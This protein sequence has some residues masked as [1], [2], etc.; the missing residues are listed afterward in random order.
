MFSKATEY[1]LRAAIYIAQKS[2]EDKKLSLDEIARGINSPKSF[3]AKTLQ[4]LS[5][6]NKIV[7][8]KTGPNGGF[9][10]TERARRLPAR[11]ILE[12]M[13]EDDLLEKCVLGLQQCSDKKPCPMHPEFKLIKSQLK[14]LFE[15]TTIQQLA[16]E[17]A[18]GE[19]KA[20]TGVMT[21]F[22]PR[23]A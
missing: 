5:A 15:N 1:A 8:S 23:L 16:D 22:P 6:G 10:M 19:N 9:Y 17:L 7:H 14:A 13:H 18:K 4:L 3:T 12:A 20:R 21:H 11:A 2:S